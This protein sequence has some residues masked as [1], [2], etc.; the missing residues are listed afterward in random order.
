MK[1]IISIIAPVFP[2]LIT[3]FDDAYCSRTINTIR[4]LTYTEASRHAAAV[5]H[6]IK[7]IAA[8]Y[9]SPENNCYSMYIGIDPSG[10]IYHTALQHGQSSW[11]GLTQEQQDHTPLEY[12][13]VWNWCESGADGPMCDE[14]WEDLASIGV[15]VSS[16]YA[17]MQEY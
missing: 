11:F 3:V 5:K 6:N 10:T 15:D 14:Y 17:R 4:S 8:C 7:V 13:M 2:S 12:D 1:S 9:P 16:L